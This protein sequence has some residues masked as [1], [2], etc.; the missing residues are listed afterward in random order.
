MFGYVT[1]AK[2]QLS[3][4]EYDRFRA[5]YCGVC[6]AM[7]RNA[8]QL[9]RLGLSYDITFLAIVLSSVLGDGGEK[10]DEHCMVHLIKKSPCIKGDSYVDYAASVGVLLSYLKLEDD[11]KDDGSIKALFGM[12][13]MLP[14]YLRVRS[15]YRDLLIKIREQLKA[16]NR[17]EK[18]D[19]R[20]IDR[21]ADTFAKILSYMFVPDT[22]EL[23]NNPALLRALE[24]FGYH[25]GRWIY[26]LDAYDDFTDDM[27]TG[28]YNP[29]KGMGEDKSSFA[30]SIDFSLTLSLS[31]L[32]EAFELMDFKRNKGLVGK[33]IYTSLRVKQH[34]ILFGD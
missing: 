12:L 17:L 5:Y 19:C 26:I 23:N 22:E 1:V 11:L 9:S 10:C 32:A 30:E 2:N 8:S 24:W 7:G 27:K 31:E 16:L 21:V 33:M 34:H 3:D 14:G 18:E 29:L 6:K 20:N 25:L 15:K 4:E 28:A 13:V